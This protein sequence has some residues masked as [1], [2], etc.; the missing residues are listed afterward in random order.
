MSHECDAG[1]GVRAGRSAHAGLQPILPVTT[2]NRLHVCLPPPSAHCRR[3]IL[4]FPTCADSN[5]APQTS[6]LFPE[7]QEL[8]L[9]HMRV[10]QKAEITGAC[11]LD[12]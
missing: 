10:G 11:I 8:A 4:C 12:Q 7:V 9:Q 1:A 2:C 5:P 3:V 6:I